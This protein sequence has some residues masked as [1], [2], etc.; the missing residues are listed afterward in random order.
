MPKEFSLGILVVSV[1]GYSDRPKIGLVAF[2]IESAEF[3]TD[4]QKPK[5]SPPGSRDQ[6]AHAALVENFMIP[7]P[8]RAMCRSP[9]WKVGFEVSVCKGFRINRPAMKFYHVVAPTFHLA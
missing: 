9:C 3:Y 1:Y 2:Y 7:F 4:W 6:Q 5:H 8:N